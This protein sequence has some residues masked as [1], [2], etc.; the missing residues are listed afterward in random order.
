[1]C[2]RGVKSVVAL[3][4]KELQIAIELVVA[5]LG[6]ALMSRPGRPQRDPRHLQRRNG[7]AADHHEP[8]TRQGF[9]ADGFQAHPPL[10]AA[11]GDAE[12]SASC[13][14]PVIAR[15]GMCLHWNKGAGVMPQSEERLAR[16]EMLVWDP[17]AFDA[18]FSVCEQV[19]HDCLSA[20]GNPC[21]SSTTPDCKCLPQSSLR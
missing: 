5:G 6:H 13:P 9:E 18:S 16:D 11:D 19:A 14:R 20:S 2:P 12:P 10:F 3:Q 15:S 8:P 7:D 4:P 17:P 1:M 21:C